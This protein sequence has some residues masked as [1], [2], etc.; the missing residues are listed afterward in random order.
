MPDKEAQEVRL[1]PLQRRLR[2]NAKH[3]HRNHRR[4][5]V[6]RTLLEGSDMG[7]AQAIIITITT[8]SNIMI[9]SRLKMH[10][11]MA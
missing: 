6:R 2:A 8:T 5:P 9:L 7:T 11:I 3:Q 1:H 4:Q 10:W